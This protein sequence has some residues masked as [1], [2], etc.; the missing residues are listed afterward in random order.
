MVGKTSFFARVFAG[1]C[2]ICLPCCFASGQTDSP[3]QENRAT[4]VL[5]VDIREAVID[6]VARDRHNLPIADLSAGEFEVFEVPEHGKSVARRILSVRT[7][8]PEHKAQEDDSTSSFHVSSGA[9]C[10]LNAAVHYRIAIPSSSEPGYHTVLVKTTRHHV[11]L[12]FRRQYYVGHTTDNIAAKELKKLVSPEALQEAACYHPLTPATLEMTARMLDAPGGTGTRYTAVIKPE[13][14]NKIGMSPVGSNRELP[15]LQLDFGMCLFNAE[16]EVTGYMHT[17]LDREMKDADVA[18]LQGDGFVSLME[19]PG[20]VPPA[21]ARLAVLDRN[22]GNLGTVDVVRP[23]SVVTQTRRVRSEPRLV[24][25]IRAFGSV[26]PRE[27]AFCGDV[28][29]LPQGTNSLSSFQKLDPVASLYTNVLDVPTQDITHMGGIPG[30]THTSEWFGIDYYGKFYVTKAGEYV[31]DLRSDDGSRLEVD[32]R[33][34]IDLD[35][36]HPSTSRTAKITLAVGWHSIH[37]PYYQGPP[38]S[39]ALVLLIQVPGEAMRPFHLNE[40]V[41]QPL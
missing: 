21:L 9:I 1:A 15:R 16:G 18:R 22:T 23:L 6:V 33:V 35:G 2:L 20:K 14:T 13:S 30:V 12:T 5:H 28:Y 34:L 40:F 36:Q 31:F 8:D 27:G 38:T 39:L 25:D 26:T 10:A 19:V 17:S 37:V 4:M 24:G 7:V 29:E 41:P 3:G 11:D 32:D